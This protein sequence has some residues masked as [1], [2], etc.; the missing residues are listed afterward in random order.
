M[1][2]RPTCNEKVFVC[3]SCIARRKDYE[4]RPYMAMS[5]SKCQ[6]YRSLFNV[7]FPGD[8]HIRVVAEQKRNEAARAETK[9]LENEFHAREAAKSMCDR[10]IECRAKLWKLQ[11]LVNTYKQSHHA[12]D[13]PAQLVF[14]FY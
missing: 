1:C 10:Y 4:V 2:K 14:P 12:P 7:R 3:I 5:G 9:K 13:L 6:M 8:V 11:E